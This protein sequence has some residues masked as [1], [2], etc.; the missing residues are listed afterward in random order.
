MWAEWNLNK[1]NENE[2]RKKEWR[3]KKKNCTQRYIDIFRLNFIGMNGSGM[4]QWLYHEFEFHLTKTIS[5]KEMKE[6]NEKSRSKKVLVK[7]KKLAEVYCVR[8]WKH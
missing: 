8:I 3:Q 7:C 1:E 6:K 4:L 5:N 2:R